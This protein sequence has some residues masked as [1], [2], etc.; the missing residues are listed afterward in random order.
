ML[1]KTTICGEFHSLSKEEQEEILNWIRKNIKESENYKEDWTSNDLSE[2]YKTTR[3]FEI[4]YDKEI[5][6][7]M[8][9]TIMKCAMIKCGYVP[10][11]TTD[12]NHIYQLEI[13]HGDEW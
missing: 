8:N 7:K 13:I 6:N 11:V 12:E 5:I 1:N 9:N 10:K 4:Y 3:L 2:V